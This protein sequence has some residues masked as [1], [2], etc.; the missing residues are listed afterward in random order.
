MR[1]L[2]GIAVCSLLGLL[3][4]THRPVPRSAHHPLRGEI[5]RW[6]ELR[7]AC[8][9]QDQSCR[10]NPLRPNDEAE[11]S[12]VEF[13]SP[14]CAPC[15]PRLAELIQ[16]E[17][18]LRERGARLELVAVLESD[19][20]DALVGDTLQRWQLER[21]SWIVGHSESERLRIS[22]LPSLWLVS[23]RSQLLWIA[24]ARVTWEGILAALEA[25]RD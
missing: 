9:A 2:W 8:A 23:S 1:R 3:G 17:R 20:P 21:S 14:H 25:A 10:K 7:R 15:Q 18:E 12:L 5:I 6:P 16:H 11:L 13:W 22:G 24:P 19:E 4:C